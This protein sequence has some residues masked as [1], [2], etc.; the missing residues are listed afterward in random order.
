[1]TGQ[2][3]PPACSKRDAQRRIERAENHLVVLDFQ[4]GFDAVFDVHGASPDERMFG[5]NEHRR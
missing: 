5:H 3:S 2:V 1:M 4:R